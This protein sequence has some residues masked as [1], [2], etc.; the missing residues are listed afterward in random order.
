MQLIV[1]DISF[2]NIR[3][4]NEKC[5]V[6]KFS[7]K[8]QVMPAQLQDFFKFNI[9]SSYLV[10]KWSLRATDLDI[11]SPLLGNWLASMFP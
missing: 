2:S 6:S 11:V 4:I 9:S 8:L 5:Q 1:S 7:R 10:E 3:E